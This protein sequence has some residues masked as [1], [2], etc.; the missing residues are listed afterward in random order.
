M[1]N[2][3]SSYTT[4]KGVGL[5]FNVRGGTDNPYVPDDPSIYVTRIR[6]D[7][8]AAFDGRLGVG[9]KIL[10]VCRFVSVHYMSHD[11]MCFVSFV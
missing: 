5:G 2:L 10:E 3:I 9:D 6:S 8:A 11:C 4:G 1:Y 7:G